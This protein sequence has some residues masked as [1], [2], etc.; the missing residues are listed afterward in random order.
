MLLEYAQ[1]N[2]VYYAA[3]IALWVGLAIF[4]YFV[5]REDKTGN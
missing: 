3:V 5:V 1:E 2:A 4:V